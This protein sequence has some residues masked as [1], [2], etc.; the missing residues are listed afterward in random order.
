MRTRIAL[1]SA[2]AA[3]L[4]LAACATTS[5]ASYMAPDEFEGGSIQAM[6]E[7]YGAPAHTETTA[8]GQERAVFVFSDRIAARGAIGASA[9]QQARAPFSAIHPGHRGPG[10][11]TASTPRFVSVTCQVEARFGADGVVSSVVA[12]PYRCESI[13]QRAPIGAGDA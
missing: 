7:A 13:R 1:L 9:A 10:G 8:D 5:T 4:T 11:A 12:E 6:V 2:A 3:S